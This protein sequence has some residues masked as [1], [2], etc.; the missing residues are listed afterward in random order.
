M[1]DKIRKTGPM[2]SPGNRMAWHGEPTP[3]KPLPVAGPAS[4]KALAIQEQ[5][6]KPTSE[7]ELRSGISLRFDTD[8]WVT[9]PVADEHKV[10]IFTPQ[11]RYKVSGE[12]GRGGM[13][14]I[15]KVFDQDM[16]RPVAMKVM[17]ESGKNTHRMRFIEEAQ[18]TGQL[19][20]PGIVPVHEIGA[21][22]RGHLY[23][24]MKL[25][26]GHSLSEIFKLL[27][28]DDEKTR[29]DYSLAKL[30]A[31]LVDVANA[32][33]FAH[34]RGVVHR[35][36][37]PGNIMIGRF[38]EVLV[39]DWGLAKVLGQVQ[40]PTTR[41]LRR[42]GSQTVVV[43]A[44]KEVDDEHV[45]SGR[46]SNMNT[47]YGTVVGTPSYMSPE[48]ARGDTKSISRLSDV[49]ALGAL[50]YEILTLTPPV[51]GS[52]AQ[53]IIA[54]V[55]AARIEP[56]E[57]RTPSRLIPGELSAIAMKALRSDPRERYQ[58]SED[59][60]ADLE[61]Y[62]EGRAVSA[63]TDSTWETISKLFRR[64][65]TAS[66]AIVIAT[67]L[68]L[69]LGTAAFCINIEERHHAEREEAKARA[70]YQSYL[71]EQNAKVKAQQQ[72]ATALVFQARAAIEA[73]KIN[74]A[75]IS[76]TL[77]ETFDDTLIEAKMLR[78]QLALAQHDY[79][80]AKEK[81]EKLLA[82]R[83]GDAV[84]TRLL[85]LVSR[86]YAGAFDPD[87]EYMIAA[88][89]SGM[90]AFYLASL[91][92]NDIDKQL[93]VLQQK[94]EKEW[95]GSGKELTLRADKFFEFQGKN[96]KLSVSD[97]NPLK[98]LPLKFLRL[99]DLDTIANLGPL[100]GMPLEE[101]YLENCVKISDL[102]PL[103]GMHLHHLNLRDCSH[104][105]D[106]S[107]L[108]GMPLEY[109]IL[110]N[111]GEFADLSLLK[112]MPLKELF[113]NGCHK[114][115]D[116]SQLV[117][118][119]LEVLDPGGTEIADLSPLS[120]IT[121]LRHLYISESE[122]RDFAPVIALPLQSLYIKLSP[123]PK[124]L[125]LFRHHPTIKQINFTPVDVFWRNLDNEKTEPPKP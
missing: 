106:F 11:D 17:L 27:R 26:H 6:A 83:P 100:L 67:V 48:Q 34:Y 45:T 92:S 43:E 12:I 72:A 15:L 115:H 19:E 99:K 39:M 68:I 97:L 101:L 81:L 90:G 25:V 9:T 96:L 16:H 7:H 61:L 110:T 36:L 86:G 13:G 22:R 50:L 10:G 124:D 56:P 89:L 1:T 52:T 79:A 85:A 103:S 55:I 112:G 20:H 114:I 74:E 65:R 49:Y 37:K 18:I 108:K 73:K 40:T 5:D 70:E 2:P 29:H 46:I 116:L 75:T 122:S 59:F 35:D 119:P 104:I 77:A 121:T 91:I 4:A 41:R 118:L 62:L 78:T 94:L 105:H 80:T 71:A 14:A 58:S 21:D 28:S 125:D 95:P 113:I 30:L 42:K 102:R 93:P 47:R 66:T 123:K 53:S 111:C 23:F 60:R 69:I 51:R 84:G 57:R 54:Q 76:V 120:K 32:I 38:G 117:D 98:G 64:N 109:L 107:M 3:A 33:A 82:L 87:L 44:P 31:I 8:E 63:K 24:T 88:E